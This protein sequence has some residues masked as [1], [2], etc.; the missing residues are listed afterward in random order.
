MI[1]VAYIEELKALDLKEGKAALVEY[2]EGFG[3]K[4]KKNQSFE[5]MVA[6]IEAHL[7]ELANEPMPEDNSGLSINDIMDQHGQSEQ[8][9]TGEVILLQ[10]SPV[11][12][13]ITSVDIIETMKSRGPDIEPV[14]HDYKILNVVEST[15]T[16]QIELAVEVVAPAVVPQI[17]A[18]EAE[19]L[20]LP[21]ASDEFELPVN[22]SPSLVMLGV[23]QSTFVTLPWWIY[24]WITQN[25]TWKT[26]PKA[27]PHYYGIDTLLSLIYYIKRDGQVRIRETR[28]SSFQILN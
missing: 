21:V 23:G 19:P 20:A 26:N 24:E 5:K 13:N 15:E 9:P 10:D 17:P 7:K 28:N 2:G 12:E 14:L 16:A 1:D 6:E 4:V 18:V 25:P 27:F 22:Y 11:E 3:I 8:I